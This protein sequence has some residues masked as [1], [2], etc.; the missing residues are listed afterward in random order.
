MMLNLQA[1]IRLWRGDT[2]EARDLA[3]KALTLF[4]KLDD[5]FGMIQALGTMNR[6]SVALGRFAEADRTVEEVL[7]L[8]DSFG[9]M[10]YPAIAAAGTA[11]HL[12]RGARA[13][14]LASGAIERLDTTGANVDEG[15]VVIAFGNLLAGDT[16][17]ALTV[18]LDVDV[19]RSPFALAARATARA[20]IGDRE[21]S[22]ADVTSV[23]AM[24]EVSYWDRS[25][26]AVAGAAAASGEEAVRRREAL[27][28]LVD[29]LDDVVISAYATEVLRLLETEDVGGLAARS[30]LPI[31]GWHDVARRL[32]AARS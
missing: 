26:A 17:A 13:A 22:I 6:A 7:G 25:V 11:M 12:G 14:E 30:D 31:D 3:E 27:G 23:E 20:L 1:S 5:R 9:E 2:E 19:E 18:L 28:V 10:A 16:E 4:R 29:E 24:S 15:R 32:A 21:G 8:S